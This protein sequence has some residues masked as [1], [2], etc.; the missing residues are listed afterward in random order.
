MKQSVPPEPFTPTELLKLIKAATLTQVAKIAM[1]AGNAPD[2]IV[3]A[4]LKSHYTYQGVY[5]ALRGA[6]YR[7]RK[8]RSDKGQT[9]KV[10]INRLIDEAKA[11]EARLAQQSSSSTGQ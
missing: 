8:E 4:A 6:G 9:L 5:S 11:L 10:K 3:D 2:D 1:K 7:M